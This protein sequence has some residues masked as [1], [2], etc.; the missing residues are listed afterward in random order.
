MQNVRRD[1][2]LARARVLGSLVAIVAVPWGLG[3]LGLSTPA[4]LGA[5]AALVAYLWSALSLA[6]T[7]R[8]PG[9]RRLVDGAAKVDGDRLVVTTDRGETALPL[10]RLDGGWT[11]KTEWG[12]TAVLSFSD[13]KVVAVERESEEEAI[14]QLEAAGAGA[15]ARAVRMRGYR[16]DTSGRKIAGF[17]LAFFALLLL[18]IAVTA[19]VALVTTV[20]SWSVKPLGVL[21]GILLGSSPLLGIVAWLWS[22]V[23]P[24]WIHIGADGVVLRGAFRKRFFPHGAIVRAAPTKGGIA[25]AYHFVK[26]DLTDGRSF[27]VP[28][29]SADESLAMIDR[30]QAASKGTAAQDRARLLEIISRNGRPVPEWKKALETLVAKTGYRTAGHDVEEVMRIVEDAAAPLEQRVA[31]ALAARPHGGEAVQKRIRVAAEACVEPRL[32]VALE[33]AAT[34]EIEDEVLEEIG[35]GGARM[36]VG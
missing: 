7:D 3:W 33:R 31:A 4:V 28:A 13:G 9:E 35:S 21:M 18:P 15:Q 25:D 16:E 14:A 29:A 32:R 5:I 11:E 6:G 17:L 22:K 20:A 26:I 23:T 24:T 34:G 8:G 27:T 36:A 12:H 19:V 1:R 10:S 30:I 2:S